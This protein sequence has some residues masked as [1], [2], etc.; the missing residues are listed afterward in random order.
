MVSV[1]AVVQKAPSSSK[2]NRVDAIDFIQKSLNR[3]SPC[4]FWAFR[5]HCRWANRQRRCRSPGSARTRA[6]ARCIG[7]VLRILGNEMRAE[8]ELSRPAIKEKRRKVKINDTDGAEHGNEHQQTAR[9]NDENSNPMDTLSPIASL[10]IWKIWNLLNHK[11][12]DIPTYYYLI[13]I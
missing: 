7:E 12:Q 2:I 13:A 3:S 10:E 4:D 5:G 9:N 11:F 6:S 8:T 1:V